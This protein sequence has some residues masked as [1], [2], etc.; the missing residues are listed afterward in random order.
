MG[1]L[2]LETRVKA[3][4]Y[5]DAMRNRAL[6]YAMQSD[7]RNPQ[8]IAL[9]LNDA[10][11]NGQLALAAGDTVH[12]LRRHL[13]SPQE[14][15]ATMKNATHQI[16]PLYMEALGEEYDRRVRS[17]FDWLRRQARQANLEVAIDQ[18]ERREVRWS[19]LFAQTQNAAQTSH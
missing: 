7:E 5:W 4:A 3:Q 19:K 10:A 18:L 15:A 13:I 16:I 6:L 17:P 11:K 12:L 8:E 9:E 14:A 1:L 2:S